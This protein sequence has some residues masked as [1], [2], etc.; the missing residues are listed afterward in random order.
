MKSVEDGSMERLEE[1]TEQLRL[2]LFTGAH[3]SPE[4]DLSPLLETHYEDEDWASSLCEWRTKAKNNPFL[5]EWPVEDQVTFDTWIVRNCLNKTALAEQLAFGNNKHEVVDGELTTGNSVAGEGAKRDDESELFLK[6]DLLSIVNA[7]KCKLVPDLQLSSS[8]N[9]N[10]GSKVGHEE[11]TDEY[12]ASIAASDSNTAREADF[13]REQQRII[14][15]AARR[16]RRFN[17]TIARKKWEKKMAWKRK[18][19]SVTSPF[20]LFDQIMEAEQ[21]ALRKK[22]EETRRKLKKLGKDKERS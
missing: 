9:E 13:L 11:E 6:D 4:I 1:E 21:E 10:S 20:P 19:P 7:V 12:F 5:H 18:D 15:L 17:A 3:A 2:A 14:L 22:Q 8:R 16:D